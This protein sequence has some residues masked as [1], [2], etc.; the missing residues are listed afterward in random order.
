M[1][2]IPLIG[3]PG[4]Q[5]DGTLLASQACTDGLWTRWQR[6]LPRK[7]GGYRNT[8]PYLTAVSR[9]ILSQAYSGNRYIYSG[10]PVGIDQFTIDVSGVS[11][12]V[13]NPTFPATVHPTTTGL[14]TGIVNGQPYTQTNSWQF[15]VQY[16]NIS[17]QN[18]VFAVCNQTQLDTANQ[19]QFPLYC[20]YAYNPSNWNFANSA[21]AWATAGQPI[22]GTNGTYGTQSGFIQVSGY[23]TGSDG[24]GGTQQ[25]LFPNGVSGLV[26]LAPYLIVYGNDGFFAWSTP[27]YPTDF[28]GVALG[29]LYVGATRI[30]A[31]KIIRGFPLRGGGGYSPAGIFF[32]VDSLVRATFVGIP[33]GTWQFDQLTNNISV[34]SDDA[35]VED[36]GVF[37]WAGV[38]HFYMFNGTVQEIPNSQ[39]INW[40]FDNINTAYAAKSF[41]FK[42][43]RYG[44]IWWCYPRGTATECSH[45]VIYNYREKCWYDTPLPD[46]RSSGIYG[47]NFIGTIMASAVPYTYYSLNSSG[48]QTQYTAYNLWQHEQGTDQVFINNAQ[49]AAVESYFTTGPISALTGNPPADVMTSIEQLKPDFIQ[50]GNLSVSVLKQNNANAPVIAG[51][52]GI[53]LEPTPTG[54]STLNQVV[55][56]KDTAKILRIKV[57]SNVI[58]GNYQA[59]RSLLVI[60]QDG[61]RDT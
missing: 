11:S 4:I 35:I 5:R 47:D 30:T 7:M 41:A 23:G 48:V 60:N 50:S 26:S 36:N 24:F 53:I 42:V 33:N 43:T 2:L 38:D 18:L 22:T 37:Y 12:A 9:Q 16:D 20:A 27:G 45:A 3:A 13:Y 15:D 14:P 44:E 10:T 19:G 61:E 6:G 52:T 57:D 21:F 58:G 1:P 55:P 8:Q 46:L 54:T 39:N 51:S 17:N 40:F 56:L 59:G 32:S 25:A 49:I 29:D 34:L 28:L 31:Q